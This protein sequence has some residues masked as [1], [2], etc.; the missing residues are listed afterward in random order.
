MHDMSG[1]LPDEWFRPDAATTDPRLPRIR[2]G[3]GDPRPSAPPVSATAETAVVPATR[4]PQEP[5]DGQ[6]EILEHRRSRWGWIIGIVAIIAALILGLTFGWLLRPR[7]DQAPPTA[8]PDVTP[9]LAQVRLGDRV[10]PLSVSASCTAQP[11]KDSLGKDVLYNAK[12]I[13]DG[14]L[15]T[16]WRC[17]GEGIG[18]T[19]SFTL[20]EGTKVAALGVL[21]GYAK[22]D[23]RTGELM[24]GQYRRVKAVQWKLPDGTTVDQKFT[25]SP[26]EIQVMRIPPVTVAGP[27][28]LT[29]VESTAP[30]WENVPT[31]N[32][33]LLSEVEFF[34]VA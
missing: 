27:I 22:T 6:W 9:S 17:D 4:T 34:P 11:A 33:V 14:K 26:S 30:G 18:T 23:P 28:K 1:N 21:N 29:I 5:D 10:A 24:Y 20:P 25:E 8:T 2:P 19:L 13:S 7:F 32:A 31:R 15:D 12:L 16:A 3:M